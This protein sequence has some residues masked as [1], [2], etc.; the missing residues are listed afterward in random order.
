VQKMFA[1]ILSIFV[2]S[3][4]QINAASAYEGEYQ[5]ITRNQEIIQALNILKNTDAK[6]VIDVAKG[7]NKSQRPIRIMFQDLEKMSPAYKTFEA[8]TCV[9]ANNKIYIFINSKH[10][11]AP[12]QALAALLSHEVLHQDDV[13]SILEETKAWTNEAKTWN[14]FV[15]KNPELASTEGKLVKRLNKLATIY[16]KKGRDGIFN[17]IKSIPAYKNL[18]VSAAAA[19]E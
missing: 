4:F 19:N 10:K 8:V 16:R 1:A 12:I 9:D 5:G 11:E 14:M 3:Y 2:L 6:W 18:A 13:N 15:K 7:N 17:K